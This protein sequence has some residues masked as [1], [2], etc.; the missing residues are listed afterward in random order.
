MYFIFAFRFILMISKQFVD[1]DGYLST[2]WQKVYDAIV[3]YILD[4]NLINTPIVLHNGDVESVFMGDDNV[5]ILKDKN[6]ISD[7]AENF[8]DE[9]L[10][11]VYASL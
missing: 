9:V 4:N 2:L 10:Y 6:G 11:K 3:Q 1:I 7:F 5:L 8:D